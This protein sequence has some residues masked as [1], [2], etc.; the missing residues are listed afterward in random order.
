MRL[1]LLN[2][3]Q[4]FLCCLTNWYSPESL[5]HSFFRFIVTIV[6][7]TRRSSQD[8][9]GKYHC[10]IPINIVIHKLALGNSLGMDPVKYFPTICVNRA[11]PSY[12][13]EW[14]RA[15]QII[16]L[17]P[18]DGTRYTWKL[19]IVL[20]DEIGCQIHEKDKTLNPQGREIMNIIDQKL[21]CS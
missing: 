11:C 20:V 14:H 10:A 3:S 15:R 9:L 17:I 6:L 4:I 7:I 18:L 2:M 21:F 12:F 16:G 19:D 13:D 5:I 8:V 1:C